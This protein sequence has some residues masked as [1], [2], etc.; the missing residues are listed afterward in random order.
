MPGNFSVNNSS[1][2][3]LLEGGVGGVPCYY[4][5]DQMKGTGGFGGGGGGCV[6]GGGGGGYTGEA[7]KINIKFCSFPE[8]E[9]F[10]LFK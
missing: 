8:F 7:V 3:S 2:K 9:K 10:A 1:G 6:A 5:S 4:S